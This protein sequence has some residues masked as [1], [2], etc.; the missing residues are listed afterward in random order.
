MND[1]PKRIEA[2][3]QQVK[4]LARENESLQGKLSRIEAGSLESQAKTV[5][6][7]TVL[8]AEVQCT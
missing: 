7:I 8:S 5:D 1:V 2:L 4:E 6:G 3:H